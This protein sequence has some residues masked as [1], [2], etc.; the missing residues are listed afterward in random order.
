MKISIIGAGNGGQAMAGHFAMLGH[1][2]CLYD[3][4]T[5]HLNTIQKS[6]GIH[7]L[8]KVNGF[9][10]I[11]AFAQNLQI[12]CEF[13]EL[14]MIVTT[15]DAHKHIAQAISPYITKNHRIVLNPGRTLGAVEFVQILRNNQAYFHSVS[16]T[17]SLLY[18]CRLVKPAEVR[19][20]GIKENILLGTVPVNKTD[21]ICTLLN[22]IYPAFIPANNVLHTSLENLGAILHPPVVMFNIAAIERGHQFAFY[23][24]MT[25]AVAGFIQSMDKERL[26]LGEALDL[27]LNSVN[28]WVSFAYRDIAGESFL[29]KVRNNPA[30]YKI[31]SPTDL[32][33]RYIHEDLPTGIVPYVEIGKM[34]G[35]ETPLMNAVLSTLSEVSDIDFRIHGRTFHKLGINNNT[36][37]E[38]FKVIN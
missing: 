7:L 1:S 27:K 37:N 35:V 19:I 6:G 21:E 23:N 33:T 28:D 32:R 34:L 10:K 14:I 13:S 36:R 30:Y 11:E 2:V 29:E 20:I 25:K 12:I 3:I 17:Q 22:D 9:G 24:D 15:A 8:G 18:A 16:E 5:Q 4:N 31:M 26:A 38:L